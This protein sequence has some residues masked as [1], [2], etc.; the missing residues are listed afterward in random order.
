MTSSHLEVTR[1]QLIVYSNNKDTPRIIKLCAWSW[2]QI[3]DTVIV[4]AQI[5]GGSVFV[6]LLEHPELWGPKQRKL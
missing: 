3:L 1:Q 2:E 6:L 5:F 4:L